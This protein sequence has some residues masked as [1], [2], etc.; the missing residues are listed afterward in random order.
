MNQQVSYNF[1]L[2]LINLISVVIISE[3]NKAYC[4]CA[5]AA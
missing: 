3:A 4:G 1:I 2:V 5:K